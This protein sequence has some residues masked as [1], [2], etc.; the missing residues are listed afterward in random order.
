MTLPSLD[1][2][3]IQATG[4]RVLFFDQFEEFFVIDPGSAGPIGKISSDQLCEA[5][6]AD[7]TLS[8]V[9][10]IREDYLAQMDPYLRAIPG[11]LRSR[12][13]LEPLGVEAARA[14][15]IG[16]ARAAGVDFEP[17]AVEMILTSLL[18]SK[19]ASA[20][21]EIREVRSAY[22]DL[23]QLQIVCLSLWQSLRSGTDTIRAMDVEML[24]GADRALQ[25]FYASCLDEVSE[26]S[27]IARRDLHRALV[28]H[29][30]T[31]FGTRGLVLH[32]TE[33][34]A[35]VPN[36]LIDQLENSR[37]I[38]SEFRAGAR[39]HELTHDRL[40]P[41]VQGWGRQF[42]GA[43]EIANQEQVAR[44]RHALEEKAA[45]EERERQGSEIW[46]ARTRDFDGWC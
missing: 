26:R 34:T 42:E 13:R 22:I 20:S 3:L 46:N 17:E 40:I 33:Q 11:R 2:R 16:P 18:V 24:G 5:L 28:D 31:P 1:S 35:G 41:A 29:F 25:D 39:W 14:A 30:I 44:E 10:S 21:G 7:R 27:S 19:A 36:P 23:A 38:R 32:N 4:S 8:V 6:H 12:L 45:R 9:F 15:V 37:L 43:D